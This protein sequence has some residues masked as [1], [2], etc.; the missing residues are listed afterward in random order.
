MKT[1]HQYQNLL[2]DLGLDQ[3][4]VDGITHSEAQ[5]ALTRLT[6]IHVHL[7]D[8]ETSLNMDIHA[9][10]SQ[11]QG[12]IAALSITTHHKAKVEEEQRAEEERDNRL[13]PYEE[14][15]SQLQALLVT[16]DEKR[17]ALEKVA[18]GA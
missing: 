9:L 16:L 17:A 10:R 15:K 2:T 8:L 5:K 4:M 11:Y 18:T 1:P 7:K 3:I 14:V 6:E 12:R 13:A